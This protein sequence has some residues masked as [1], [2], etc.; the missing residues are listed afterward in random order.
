MNFPVPV[1]AEPQSTTLPEGGETVS[2]QARESINTTGMERSLTDS[3]GGEN[4]RAAGDAVP[5]EPPVCP[6][7]SLARLVETR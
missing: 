4:F 6:N 3:R 7:F 2:G 1:L 5:G